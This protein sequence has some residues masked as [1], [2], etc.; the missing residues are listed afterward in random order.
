MSYL[1]AILLGILQGL[2]EFLPV[3]SSGHLV[4]AQALLGV[5]DPGVT[6]EVLAHLG[7]LFSVVVYF[8]RRITRLIQSLYTPSMLEERRMLLLLIIGSIPAGLAGILFKDFFEAAFNDPL[9]TA[10]M[11]FVTGAILLATRFVHKGDKSVQWLSALIMG[12]GQACAILPGISRSGST[13]AAGMFVGVN[14]ALAAEFSFLMA[15]PAIAGA[16]VLQIGDVLTADSAHLLPYL[17][18]TVLSFLTG[19]VAVYAV[20]ATIRRG[21]FDYFAYYCFAAGALALYLFL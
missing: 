8:R 20:L 18:G 15:I 3:S 13:I 14:P 17:L 7:T 12:A 9:S 2:T 5:S 1:D 21:A 4:I 6:F 19:L 16:A 11:L 10:A